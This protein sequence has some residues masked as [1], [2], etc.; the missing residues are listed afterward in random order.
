MQPTN[1]Q[2]NIWK[3][4]LLLI[5]NKRIF[6]AILSA[7]YLTIPDVTATTIGIILLFGNLAGFILEVPSGYISDKLGHKKALVM[8]RVLMIISTLFFLFA[9]SIPFLILG[10]V[11][12]SISWAFMSGTAIA[13]LHETLRGLGRDNEFTKISGKASSMGFAV[14]IALTV[15]APFLIEINLKA[16]FVLSLLLDTIG[17][18]V[19]ISLAKPHVEQSHIDE[20]GITNFKDVIKAGYKLGF[21]KYAFFVAIVAAVLTVVSLY[22]GPYQLVLDIPIIW[23]GVLFGAGRALASII[24]FWSGH[25]KDQFKDASSFFAFEIFL[26][27]SLLLILA[28]TKEPWVVASAFIAINAFQWGFGQITLGYMIEVIKDSKFKATLLSAQ[29]QIKTVAVATLSLAFGMQI[30]ATSYQIAY[31]VILF[32]FIAVTVPLYIYIK[33]KSKLQNKSSN[34]IE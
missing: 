16:P 14:P 26:Y 22:R 9:E 23:F 20:V 11:F 34:I 19:V 2:S 30:E 3:Y 32:V 13:F 18:L 31:I 17:L 33:S 28:A 27:S 29:S 4:T 5:V 10:S 24:L 12:L 21:F 6:A 7:Y 1:L 15:L 25:L 8:S